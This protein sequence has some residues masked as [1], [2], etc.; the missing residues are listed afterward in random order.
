MH[1]AQD[2]ADQPQHEGHDGPSSSG[3]GA[4][5]TGGAGQSQPTDDQADQPHRDGHKGP[6]SPTGDSTG[7]NVHSEADVGGVEVESYA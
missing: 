5:T 6:G 1:H 7:G 3:A 2:H 4:D